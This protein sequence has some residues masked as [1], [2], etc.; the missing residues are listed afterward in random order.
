MAG[1]RIK[2]GDTVVVLAGKDKGKTG[3]VLVAMPKDGKLLVDGVN[4]VKRHTKQKS[5]SSQ[6]GIV[7]KSMPIDVSN[8]AIAGPG[9][10]PSKVGFKIAADG[11]KSRINKRTGAAL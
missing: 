11:T 3:E 8:V 1:M 9:N 4:V 2:K 6:A 5:A 7:E 10:K